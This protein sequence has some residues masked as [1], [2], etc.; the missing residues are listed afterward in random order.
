MEANEL[1]IGNYVLDSEN[2]ICTIGNGMA[3]FNIEKIN[4][5]PLTEE[6]LEK[7]GFENQNNTE[8]QYWARHEKNGFSIFNIHTIEI[9]NEEKDYCID[10]PL[11]L[12][13]VHQLQNIYFALTGKELI[14]KE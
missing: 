6:W 10:L 9:W 14:K 3:F 13:Y 8:D 4:P 12:N 5:I 2:K 7:F 11:Y 1:R